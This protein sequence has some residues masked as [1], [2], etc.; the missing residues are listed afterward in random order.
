MPYSVKKDK[1]G[2]YTVTAKDTGKTYNTKNPKKLERLHE[3]FKHMKG[4]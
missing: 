1:D 4:E 3:M 2:M